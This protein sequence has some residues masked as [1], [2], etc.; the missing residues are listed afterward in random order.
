MR[1]HCLFIAM[2]MLPAIEIQAETIQVPDDHAT[3]Q[4]AIDASDD[5]DVIEIASG[6]YQEIG[7]TTGGKAITLRG[8]LDP[9]G[10]PITIIDG[11]YQ[12]ILMNFFQF[13]KFD[14]IFQ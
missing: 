12:G 4:Q 7:I 5:G 1:F 14:G 6:T 11:Q 10:I 9:D 3:I 2:V 13:A 8:T